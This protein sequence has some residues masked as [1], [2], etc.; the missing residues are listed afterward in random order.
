VLRITWLDY[1]RS[2]LDCFESFEQETI[3]IPRCIKKLF[4]QYVLLVIQPT[5]AFP[6]I[7]CYMRY[8]I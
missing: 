3:S 1:V 2:V 8:L 4:H 6:C 5:L 7:L